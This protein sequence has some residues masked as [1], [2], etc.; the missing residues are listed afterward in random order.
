MKTIIATLALITLTGCASYDPD[1]LIKNSY[2]SGRTHTSMVHTPGGSYVV[3]TTAN[4]TGNSTT[5]Y[6]TTGRR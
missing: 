3:R 1:W 6:S 2:G 4:S 5:I